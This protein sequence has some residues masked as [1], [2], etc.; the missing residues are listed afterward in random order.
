MTIAQ[1]DRS[2]ISFDKIFG[3]LTACG[4]VVFTL[5]PDSHSLMVLYPFVSMWQLGLMLPIL[6]FLSLLWQGKLKRLDS[7]WDWGILLIIIGLTIS[8]LFARFH[9]QAIWYGWTAVCCLA[10]VYV[11]NSN[12]NTPQDRYQILVKQGY[13]NIAFILLSL[14]LWTFETLLPELIRIDKLKQQEINLQFNFSVLEL[15]NWA[16]IG[17]QNYVA[18]YLLLAISLLVGLSIVDRTWRRWLWVT[19]VALGLV[20]LYTTSSKGGWLGAIGTFAIAIVCLLIFSSLSRLQAI[21]IGFGGLSVILALFITNNR[22]YSLFTTIIRGQGG[23]EFIYRQIN[24]VLGWEMGITHPLTGVGLGGVPLLYQEYRPVWAGRQSELVYQLHGTLPQ[25]WAEMGIWAIVIIVAAITLWGLAIIKL[26]G[27]SF[28]VSNT[29]YIFCWSIYLG[30]FAYGIMSLTDY[31]LDNISISGTL[32]I[33]VACLTSALRKEDIP[34]LQSPQKIQRYLSLTGWG[35]TI[36]VIVWL[37]PIHQAWQL[38]SEGFKALAENDTDTFVTKLTAANRIAPWESYYSYQLGWNLGELAR[39][40]GDPNQLK[41]AIHW[42]EKAIAASPYQEFGHSNLGWLLLNVNPPEATQAFAKSARLVPAK[43][44]IFYGLGLSLLAQKKVISAIEAFTL[45]ALQ[46]PLFITSPIWRSPFLAGIYPQ[47]LSSV[48]TK[49]NR[50]LNKDPKNTYLHL[51]RGSLYWWQGNLAA[52]TKDWE[53]SGS[54]INQ[55]MS[56]INSDSQLQQQLNTLPDSATKTLIT[57]WFDQARRNELLERAWLQS[58]TTEIPETILTQ[59]ASSMEQ[60]NNFGQWLKYNAPISPRRF[61][62]QGFGVVNRHIDGVIPNDYFLIVDNIAISTWFASLFPVPGYDVTWENN[63][64][65]QREALLS[66]LT[67]TETGEI[68]Q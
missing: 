29:D 16:P 66:R 59:L 11:I 64:Q 3:L 47:F 1:S 39:T 28:N 10:A 25:L 13:L 12:L 55:L 56:N 21:L 68:F 9:P 20:D 26:I 7:G 38:S 23:S 22:F 4:Y 32:V 31:Q 67:A 15:R 48:E 44:G 54:D 62:R 63:L 19:S 5:A 24:A 27:K 61:Q 58:T 51:C 40:N 2:V 18:G 42:F 53:D 49:Y 46:E 41:E 60:S 43:Q 35:M 6:W 57:A 34:L 45:E 52:A 8:T 36:A 37:I 65:K 14:T 30:L 50:L 33:W 17:H